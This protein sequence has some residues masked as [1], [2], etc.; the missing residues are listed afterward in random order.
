MDVATYSEKAGRGWD[1]FREIPTFV[2][3]TSIMIFLFEVI[4]IAAIDDRHY[5]S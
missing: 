4:T 5:S 2:Q 1:E 3:L